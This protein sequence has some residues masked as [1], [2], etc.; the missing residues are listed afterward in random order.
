MTVKE[1][2]E[3][4]RSNHG[5]FLNPPDV[6]AFAEDPD[7]ELHKHFIWDD[8]AA[9]QQYRLEQARRVIRVHVTLIR[10][11]EK[12][13]P[14]EVRAYVSLPKDRGELGYRSI[15]DVMSDDE[16]RQQMLDDAYAEMSV[17]AQ[18]YRVL[19]ELSPVIGAIDK[20][21]HQ[22]AKRKPSKN[23]KAKQPEKLKRRPVAVVA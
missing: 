2:L 6:V 17:F 7:T 1:E 5:G 12:E 18:K 20:A 11:Q 8:T 16:L 22:A 19:K 13:E 4:I 21:M 10:G 23:G 15:E 9:A 3:L 14:V